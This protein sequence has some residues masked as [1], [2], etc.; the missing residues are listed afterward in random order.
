M[1][2]AHFFADMAQA[3]AFDV[4]GGGGAGGGGVGEVIALNGGGA[5]C[6]GHAPSLVCPVRQIDH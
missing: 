3:K 2:S 4:S 6:D 1:F 5:V